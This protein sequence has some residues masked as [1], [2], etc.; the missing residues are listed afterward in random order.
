VVVVC[1]PIYGNLTLFIDVYGG[2]FMKM[3]LWRCVY[4]DVFLCYDLCYVFVLE[5][6]FFKNEVVSLLLFLF[7]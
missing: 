4:G 3:C 1:F 6:G 2:E 5:F 7:L